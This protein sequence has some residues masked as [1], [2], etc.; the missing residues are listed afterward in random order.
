MKLITKNSSI[1]TVTIIIFLSLFSK[2]VSSEENNTKDIEDLDFKQE[3]HISI[4]TSLDEA[5]L[6]PIDIHVNFNNPC[7]AKNETVHSV[8]VC[9]EDNL[10][11]NEIESQIY[12]LEY[13]DEIHIKSCNLVFLIP[14]TANGKERYY[15]FYDSS[16]TKQPKYLDHI[17]LEDTHYF[18]EP[19]PGQKIDFDY[20]QIKEDGYVI[21]AIIQNGGLLGNPVAL[22]VIKFKLGSTEVETNNFDQL[23]IFEMRYDI[24]NYPWYYGTSW[25]EK[26]NKNILVDGNLMV[27]VRIE[28]ISPQGEFKTDNI[29]TYYYCPSETKK[30][31]VNAYHEVIKTPEIKDSIAIDGSYAGIVTIK[32]RSASIEKMNVGDILPLLSIYG[33]DNIIKDFNFPKD[34]DSVKPEYILTT[35]DDCDLGEKAWV[36]LSDPSSGRAHGLIF[37][38][39]SGLVEGKDDGIQIKAYTVQNVKLPGLEADSGTLLCTRNAYEKVGEQNIILS[40]GFN[41]NFNIEFISVEKKWIS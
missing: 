40:K 12:D 36:C 13:Q 39:N 8:H 26:V 6:Q 15:V 27:R 41:V 35:E 23:G 11:L 7:W 20:Y 4:D 29:Y 34:P 14:E 25:A 18:Y 3:L 32:S 16:E 24:N 28:G 10:G 9:Y 1:L 21:Y 22:A 19:I 5:K 31:Y 30:I 38:S 33:E 37:N 2:S 17:I